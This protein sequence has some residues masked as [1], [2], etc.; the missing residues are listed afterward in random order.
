ME[1]II[2]CHSKVLGAGELELFGEL[3]GEI[4]SGD[5]LTEQKQVAGNSTNLSSGVAKVVKWS[6]LCN[7]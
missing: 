4:A 2:S 3:A 6:S 7:R 1:Q 5:K